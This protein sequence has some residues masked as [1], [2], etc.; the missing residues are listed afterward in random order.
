M[1]DLFTNEN[2]VPGIKF[3][4]IQTFGWQT[5]LRGMRNP[6]ESWDKRDSCFY[7]NTIAFGPGYP[8]GSDFVDSPERPHIG[9][10]D[11]YRALA[12]IRNGGEHRK[13]L[14]QIWVGFDIVLPIYAWSEFDTYKI[15]VTRNSCSTMYK[16]GSRVLT[17]DDFAYQDVDEPA[18]ETLNFLGATM[19]QAVADGDKRKQTLCLKLMKRRLPGGYLQ[20]ATITANYEVYLNMFFQRENHR[21]DEWSVTEENFVYSICTMIH[22]LPYMAAFIK[23][24]DKN[25]KTKEKIR[26]IIDTIF[27]EM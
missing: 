4:H 3:E 14:R 9:P 19:R 17:K 7:E 21:L 16:L 1:V 15:G 23:A 18:L 27:G 22:D 25:P 2:C 26:D 12:L 11:L 13:F 6:A 24:K 8:Y 5:A 10:N 20:R